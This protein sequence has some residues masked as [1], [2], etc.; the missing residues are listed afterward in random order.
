MSSVYLDWRVSDSP[1]RLPQKKSQGFPHPHVLLGMGTCEDTEHAQPG[2]F[3]SPAERHIQVH[4]P[5]VTNW[6]GLCL[7]Q[8][9][10]SAGK[11]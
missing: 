4:F 5:V 7:G 1:K 10:E 3:G 6:D 2:F 11:R 8:I 9:G